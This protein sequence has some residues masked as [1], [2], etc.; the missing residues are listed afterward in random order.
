[1]RNILLALLIATPVAGFAQTPADVAH[2]L[3]AGNAVSVSQAPVNTAAF[4]GSFSARDLVSSSSASRNTAPT[5]TIA[6]SMGAADL[7]RLAGTD[8]AQPT[9]GASYHVAAR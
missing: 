7:A 2:L 8:V 3:Q 4:A 1:M 6:S 9:A 5:V